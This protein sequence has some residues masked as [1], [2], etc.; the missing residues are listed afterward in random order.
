[1]W[2]LLQERFVLA[3][4]AGAVAA[5]SYSTGFLVAPVAAVWA[6]SR[7]DGPVRRI[8]NAAVA[9]GLAA[10]GLAAVFAYHQ[11][12]LGSWDAFFLV[13]AKYDHRLV[14]PLARIVSQAQRRDVLATPGTETV[15]VAALFAALAIFCLWRG[16]RGRDLLYLGCSALFW[17]FPLCL[18]N[19]ELTRSEALVFPAL[20]L[21]DEAP[22]AA[23]A[24]ACVA[25]ALLAWPIAQLFFRGVLV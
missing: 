5:A 23:S 13:Q 20:V 7:R 3:G 14:S 2:L 6:L 22:V 17:L 19:V 9:G 1:L 8:A 21:L 4:L 12:A 18:A 25:L 24:C 16:L 15:V 10:C 11:A